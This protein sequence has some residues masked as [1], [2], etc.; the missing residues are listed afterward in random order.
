MEEYLEEF[1][2]FVDKFA[3]KTKNCQHLMGALIYREA[4][5]TDLYKK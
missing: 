2:M 1:R 3:K 5:L 4:M